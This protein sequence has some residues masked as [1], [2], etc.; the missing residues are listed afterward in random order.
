M[1]SPVPGAEVMPPGTHPFGPPPRVVVP[2]GVV[3]VPSTAIVFAGGL[4][5]LA[6][7]AH[8]LGRMAGI[9]LFDLVALAFFGVGAYFGIRIAIDAS[10][11]RSVFQLGQ[12]VAGHLV[13]T[14]K[15]TAK[16]YSKLLHHR[17]VI[18]VGNM[19]IEVHSRAQLNDRAPV[20]VFVL[21]GDGAVFFPAS[22]EQGV[23]AP[24]HL[25][26]RKL[27]PRAVRQG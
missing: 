23:P 5:A 27:V 3:A 10:K 7:V 18:A 4:V 11:A 9:A 12:V 19:Q 6:L 8:Q 24:A 13:H 17:Y 14:T 16:G 20:P 25:E 26:I 2:P 1:A 15:V 21:G 22:S